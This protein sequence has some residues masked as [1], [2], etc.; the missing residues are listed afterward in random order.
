MG[1]SDWVEV[2][3]DGDEIMVRHREEV[4]RGDAEVGKLWQ[5]FN[6]AANQDGDFTKARRY[7]SQLK[8]WGKRNEAFAKY[9]GGGSPPLNDDVFREIERQMDRELRRQKTQ[10]RDRGTRRR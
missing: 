2:G 9:G 3:Q 10:Q 5:L 7:L 4:R 1:V 8:A 6:I